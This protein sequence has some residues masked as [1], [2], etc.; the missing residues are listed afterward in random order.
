MAEPLPE[1]PI[2]ERVE[3][4]LERPSE[5]NLPFGNMRKI[6]AKPF[7][8]IQTPKSKDS[9]VLDDEEASIKQEPDSDLEVLVEKL[10][11]PSRGRKRN[12]SKSETS[13]LGKRDRTM[14]REN[15]R[16]PSDSETESPSKMA[17]LKS[18]R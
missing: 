15:F 1:M 4:G 9:D 5:L 8:N 13:K 10:A 18:A 16:A 2:E 14:S 12:Q 3:E 6:D 11:K 7:D 17:A